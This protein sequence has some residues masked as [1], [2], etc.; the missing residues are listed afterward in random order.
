MQPYYEAITNLTALFSQQH[1]NDDYQ[2]L[3]RYATAALCRK[4]SSLLLTWKFNIWACLIL[5][6]LGKIHFLFDKNNKPY[7]RVSDLAEEF[8]LSRSAI[9]NKAEEVQAILKM[10][11]FTHRWCLPYMLKDNYLAWMIAFNGIAV[12]QESYLKSTKRLHIKKD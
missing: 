1:L 8:N 7:F 2:L 11:S 5:Y 3:A 12:D 10:H 4:K 9:I 6:S